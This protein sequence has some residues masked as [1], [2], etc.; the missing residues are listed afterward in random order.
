MNEVEAAG[1][2][3]LHFACYEGW[4][5]GCAGEGCWLGRRVVQHCWAMRSNPQPLWAAVQQQRNQLKST[6]SATASARSTVL[7]RLLPPTRP[8]AS[9]C[10]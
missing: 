4:L 2:T 8:A 7:A 3:P 6:G 10:C 5:E 1:N 9:S